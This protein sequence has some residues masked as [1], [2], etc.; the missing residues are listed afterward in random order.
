MA[1]DWKKRYASLIALGAVADGP[2]KQSFA[3][4]IQ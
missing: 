1:A 3:A 2:E 4:L